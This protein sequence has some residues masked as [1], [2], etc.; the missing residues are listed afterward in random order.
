MIDNHITDDN[1]KSHFE[2]IYTPKKLESHLTIFIVFD[3]ETH[4]TDRARPYVFS[5]YRSSKLSERYKRD[6]TPCETHN[7][8]KDTN[9]FD[10]DECA[11][12]ASDFCLK[13]KCDERKDKKNKVLENN[14]QLYA[15]NGSGF[16]TWIILNNFPCD[17][18][19]V[20]IIK[21]GK[22]IIE[23]EIFNGYIQTNQKENPQYLY[24]RCGMTH[25]N[26]SL[27]KLAKTFKL[28]HSLLKIEM[29]HDDVVGHNYKIRKHEGLDYV[30]EDVL[31]TAFSYAIYSKA[32]EEITGISLQDFFMS[33]KSSLGNISNLCEMKMMN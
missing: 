14:L 11:G 30:K 15:H 24:F 22:S 19:T 12:N 17:G 23:F 13:L 9:A 1:V 5:F 8:K 7:C 29:N 27:K 32:M 21:N 3:L 25:L 26:S 16:D 18:S 6:I 28:Q 4:N 33:A 10:V 2:Y 20:Y 31:C